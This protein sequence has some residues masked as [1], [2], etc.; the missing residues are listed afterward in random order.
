MGFRLKYLVQ[1]DEN[2]GNVS[3]GSRESTKT[4][5]NRFRNYE[6]CSNL[7][8]K[9]LNTC[10]SVLNLFMHFG[11]LLRNYGF[12]P[13][14]RINRLGR[15]LNNVKGFSKISKPIVFD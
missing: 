2:F 14:V 9:K 12:L 1:T 13:F 11:H 4:G 6:S 10:M 5:V 15:T 8:K 7:N 3:V